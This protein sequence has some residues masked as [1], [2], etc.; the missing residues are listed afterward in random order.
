[1]SLSRSA[2]SVTCSAKASAV[3]A[4]S[5][6]P[7]QRSLSLSSSARAC[8]FVTFS[9]PLVHTLPAARPSSS[10]SLSSSTRTGC[11]NRPGTLPSPPGPSARPGKDRCVVSWI[12]STRRPAALA[13]HAAPADA[14]TSSIVT[15]SLLRNRPNATVPARPCPSARTIGVLASASRSSPKRPAN[16]SA[17][18]IPIR[19]PRIKFMCWPAKNHALHS[20]TSAPKTRSQKCVHLLAVLLGDLIRDG[21]LLWLYCRECFRERDVDPATIPLPPDGP[22]P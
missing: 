21:K 8:R 3:L 4:A 2:I 6:S 12:A 17:Q 5:P 14:K 13:P 7:S 16:M 10:P 22:V 15:L 18:Q 1:M 11:R 20:V 9:G 19:P